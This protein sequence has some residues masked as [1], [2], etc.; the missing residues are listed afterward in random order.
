[1]VSIGIWAASLRNFK[2]NLAVRITAATA[3]LGILEFWRGRCRRADLTLR[4]SSEG[5][6]IEFGRRTD[7]S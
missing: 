7:S 1:M 3:D 4:A 6:V 5:S 2:R